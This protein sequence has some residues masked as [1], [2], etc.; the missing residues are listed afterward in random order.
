MDPCMALVG[1]WGQVTTSESSDIIGK[2]AGI[3]IEHGLAS[4]F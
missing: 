1:K 2:R 3:G 4:V